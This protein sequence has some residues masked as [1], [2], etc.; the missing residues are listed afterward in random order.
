MVDPDNRVVVLKAAIR[1]EVAVMWQDPRQIDPVQFAL[2]RAD[3]V[4]VLKSPAAVLLGSLKRGIKE[5]PSEKKRL[6]CRRNGLRPCKPGRRR[7]R[8]KKR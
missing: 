4:R 1:N 5:Q 2:F 6:A 7:G 8:P 3:Q